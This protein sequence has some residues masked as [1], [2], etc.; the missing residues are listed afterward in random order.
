MCLACQS[1]FPHTVLGYEL[2]DPF[3]ILLSVEILN[4]SQPKE[5]AHAGKTQSGG[6]QQQRRQRL[7][8]KSRY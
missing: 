3:G 8:R 6:G 4:A 5:Q 1:A 2:D 7:A